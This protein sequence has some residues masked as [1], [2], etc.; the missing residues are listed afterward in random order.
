MIKFFKRAT[1]ILAAFSSIGFAAALYMCVVNHPLLRVVVVES[2]GVDVYIT[3]MATCFV[4]VFLSGVA[5]TL[6][7]REKLYESR[8]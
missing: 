2:L 7:L 8:W 5:H 3:I 1:A 6:Y 4:A